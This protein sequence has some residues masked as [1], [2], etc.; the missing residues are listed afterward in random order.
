MQ[1]A[2][3]NKKCHD[4]S[5]KDAYNTNG[6]GKNKGKKCVHNKLERVHGVHI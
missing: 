6:K 2:K 5:H 4:M 1:K 3:G